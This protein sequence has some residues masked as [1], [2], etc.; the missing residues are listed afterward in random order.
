MSDVQQTLAARE[1]TYGSFMDVANLSQRLQAVMD[2]G[3]AELRNDQREALQMICSKIARILCGNPD[4]IDNWH[5]IAG[6]AALVE[7]RLA[8][9]DVQEG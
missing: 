3:P 2:D 8:A 9:D 1:K 7:R 6:Y 5:D 4:Y